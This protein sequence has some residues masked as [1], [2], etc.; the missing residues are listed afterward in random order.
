MNRLSYLD[1]TLDLPEANLALDE[2]LLESVEA[3]PEG[4]EWLRIWEM[5]S[6]VVV[7]GRSTQVHQEVNLPACQR[8][9]IPVLRRCS[10]GTS[11]VVG[12]GCLLYSVVLSYQQRPELRHLD[13]AHRFVMERIQSAVNAFVSTTIEGICDL[14]I[15]GKKCSG[16]SVRCKRTAL[17]YHGTLLYDFSVPMIQELL[18][19]PPRQPDYRQSRSHQDF[20]TTIPATAD[21][22][23]SALI[24]AWQASEA[25]PQWPCDRT[26]QLIAERYGDPA[27]HF[28]R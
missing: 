8:R 24:D 13:V 17:L 22:L 3:A 6:P 11:V 9:G 27:W 26:E 7:V 5:P 21:Q 15:E 12:P 2:A 25:L 23:K 4:P 20:L 19:E 1:L 28:K 16:N 14:A 10:G 18:G